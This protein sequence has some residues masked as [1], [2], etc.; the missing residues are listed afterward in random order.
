MIKKQKNIQTKH[1]S[2]HISILVLL[3]IFIPIIV[4]TQTFAFFTSKAQS[5]VNSISFGK[6]ST[7]VAIN[8]GDFTSS[9]VI[10]LNK[11][12][13]Q[14]DKFLNNVKVKT[15][16][17]SINS[18][19]RVKV[20]YIVDSSVTNSDAIT[21]AQNMCVALNSLERETTYSTVIENGYQWQYLDGYYYLVSN[22]G[23]LLTATANTAYTIFSGDNTILCPSLDDLRMENNQTLENVVLKVVCEA[24]QSQNLEVSTVNDLHSLILNNSI[25]EKETVNQY[26]VRFDSNGGVN[27]PN[28][29]VN[30]NQ[31]IILPK[32]AN[33][34]VEWF[35]QDE[36]VGVSGTNYTIGND[37]VLNA[38]Y[39]LGNNC[40]YVFFD[41]NGATNGTL[42]EVQTITYDESGSTTISIADNNIQKAGYKLVGWKI[43]DSTEENRVTYSNSEITIPNNLSQA[44]TAITLTPIW[45]VLTYT[46]TFDIGSGIGLT[47]NSITIMSNYKNADDSYKL[48]YNIEQDINLPSLTNSDSTYSFIGWKVADSSLSTDAW[49]LAEVIKADTT[50][51]GLYGDVVVKPLW[52]IEQIIKY[53]SLIIEKTYGDE[54][55]INPITSIGASNV[56]FSYSSSNENVTKINA[57]TGKVTIVGVAYESD[58][59]TPQATTITA[60]YGTADTD[61]ISYSLYVSPRDINNVIAIYNDEHIV[62]GTQIKPVVK[63]QDVVNQSTAK[64]NLVA[65]TDYTITYGDNKEVGSGTI[66]L[67]GKGNYTSTKILT[68]TIFSS[69]SESGVTWLSGETNPTADIGS[70]G[71]LYL[72]VGTG[73]VFRKTN[74]GWKNVGSIGYVTYT[75]FDGY[76]WQGK[77]RTSIK[78]E[79]TTPVDSNSRENTL[80]ITETMANYYPG[81]YL[82]LTTS[83]IAIM[84]SYFKTIG[85][86]QY[87]GTTISKITIYAETDGELY[88]GSGKVADVIQAKK[89][90]LSTITTSTSTPY[91]VKAGLNTLEINLAIGDDETLILGGNGSVGLYYSKSIPV[92]D[93][94]GGFSYIN[95]QV[96]IN[97]IEM[98]DGYNDTLAIQVYVGSWGEKAKPVY[99]GLKEALVGKMSGYNVGNY[100][101]E[102][103]GIVMTEGTSGTTSYQG[104][105]ITKLGFIFADKYTSSTGTVEVTETT[106]VVTLYV[107]KTSI[108]YNNLSARDNYVEKYKLSFE[109]FTKNT[110]SGNPI[111][112]GGL[113][114]SDLVTIGENPWS[115]TTK[116]ELYDSTTSSYSTVTSIKV[117]SDEMLAFSVENCNVMLATDNAGST[118]VM[119]N[120]YEFPS[121]DLNYWYLENNYTKSQP[122]ATPFDI[123]YSDGSDFDT[124]FAK[125]EA[126]ENEA[127][128]AQ[129][130]TQIKNTTNGKSISF[131]GDSLTAFSGWSNNTQYNTT[132]GS[133]WDS[134]GVNSFAHSG[135]T[136][137]NQTWWKQAA[138]ETG[139][140][141]LVNNSSSGSMACND[142]SQDGGESQS[143]IN[144]CTQLHNDTGETNVNPDII[145]VYMGINDLLSSNTVDTFKTAYSTIVTSITT[146]YTN[147][148]VYV[149]TLPLIKL[150]NGESTGFVD[151]TRLTAFNDAIR[152][153]GNANGCT[154]VEVYPNYSWTAENWT[155]YCIT[156]TSGMG[157][158]NA[159]GMDLITEAFIDAMY[160][161]YVTNA[162]G[163]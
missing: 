66:V 150:M 58:G 3:S 28:L 105:T 17:D 30:K 111:Y 107:I 70:L 159:N 91:T 25:F 156:V 67:T 141:V 55:F 54:D 37:V 4:F 93:T 131:L 42:P 57:T 113:D 20:N 10:S 148:E 144:R 60:K 65:D 36:S 158:P 157:H 9:S 15:V 1:Y 121:A 78:A 101:S 137:V 134:Y 142:S 120:S 50:A 52:G 63:V 41:L 160:E 35:K 2:S 152:E 140:N 46:I 129:K 21:K 102:A 163:N 149:F 90:S 34:D 19:I 98:H 73:D 88:V 127:L 161:N 112:N 74:T 45:E 48:Q 38:H 69:T 47:D 153:I 23:E 83:Q 100:G 14:G 118:S 53:E 75:G 133:N 68:F 11:T 154:V 31:D 7:K 79:A 26:F 103:S 85:K 27:V 80:S 125:L 5:D 146:T 104:K 138:D 99:E 43:K 106:A 18:F 139:M 16:E 71:N 94:I 97:I 39:T 114:W 49:Q 96:N 95:G 132:L 84:S 117:E 108:L 126:E 8:D 119:G 81:D 61:S 128:N 87:S 40:F 89:D 135:V 145:A 13:T 109:N 155:E 62:T 24:I 116:I 77:T 22:D 82:N 147:A 162:T 33:T 6:L 76:V 72:N 123:Y 86:T 136:D 115:Y 124:N 110:A 64:Q 29:V 51:T 143:G 122:C 44:S 151:E 12:L 59:T 56:T 32:V 130:T 92:S